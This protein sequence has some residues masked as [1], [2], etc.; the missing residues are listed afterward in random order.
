VPADDGVRLVAD[1]EGRSVGTLLVIRRKEHMISVREMTAAS[2]E[3]G[4][5]YPVKTESAPNPSVRDVRLW[6]SVFLATV[7]SRA[8][9]TQR[10]YAERNQWY[11][12]GTDHRL[13]G[14][15]TREGTRA[16]WW[17]GMAKEAPPRGA[18]CYVCATM[19]HTYDVSSVMSHAA[20]AAVMDHRAAHIRELLAADHA[21]TSG[22]SK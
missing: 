15:V 22:G 11:A 4:V 20:R 5:H 19:I 12:T 21:L 3:T 1:P 14:Q 9:W 17:W 7:R 10:S 6:Y 2:L 16:A 8:S 18:W 13:H